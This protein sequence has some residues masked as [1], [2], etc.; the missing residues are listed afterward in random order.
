MW[1]FFWFPPL[2]IILTRLSQTVGHQ[3]SQQDEGEW[4][5]YSSSSCPGE[6]SFYGEAISCTPEIAD[7]FILDGE[8]GKRL[9]RM[10]PVP[11]S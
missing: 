6:K 4:G 5:I 1:H 3:T 7:E 8:L 11:V 2:L 9:N 10:I